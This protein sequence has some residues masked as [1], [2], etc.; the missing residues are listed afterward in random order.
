MKIKLFAGILLS[1]VLTACG[2]GGGGSTPV[3][4]PAPTPTTTFNMDAAVASTFTTGINLQGL[5]AKDSAGN[6]YTLTAVNTP[7]ADDKF[8]GVT[9]KKVI[10]G[11][12]VSVN[13]IPAS[14]GSGSL[15]YA[16][17][18]TRILGNVS[19]IGNVTVNQQ[20]TSLPTAG[21]V[22]TSG[23]YSTGVTYSNSSLAIQLS[24]NTTLW[25]LEADSATTAWACMTTTT[26][27]SGSSSTFKNCYRISS[28]GVISGAKFTLSIAGQTLTFQ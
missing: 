27:Q 23:A 12:S 8:L 13:G 21:T 26:I 15:Y 16:L 5:S 11:V 7:V 6:T 24:T 14:V 1:G 25:S 18:P 10:Q 2:G 4:A 20:L 3:I 22:S 19:D 17:S 28:A 9:Q